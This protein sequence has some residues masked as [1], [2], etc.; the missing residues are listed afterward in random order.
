MWHI[1]VPA[2]TA[3]LGSGFDSLGMALS[4]PLEC[5]YSEAP[6][7]IISARG[8]GEGVVAETEEN[9]VWKTA[10]WLYRDYTGNPLPS[11][12]L[13]VKSR[14]PLARG[15]G[16]SAA[17]I[18]AGLTLANTLLPERLS[19][20]TLLD[21][22]TR[23][24]GHPDNVA[25]A[26]YGGFV[27]AW[28]DGQ[29]FRVQNYPAPDLR[30]LVLIPDFPVSTEKARA[31][32]PREVPLADAVFNAQRLALWIDAVSRRDWT[33]LRHA[34]GDRLHQPYRAPLIPGLTAVIDA[35]LGAGAAFAALS[36]SGPTLLS[37]MTSDVVAD[38][39]QAMGQASSMHMPGAIQLI[40]ATPSYFGAECVLDGWQ[41]QRGEPQGRNH[42]QPRIAC[43]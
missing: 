5:W 16:S 29:K 13:T 40:D 6:E 34:G 32:L 36:G 15:L 24:E 19:R 3:N 22:A 30:C 28:H 4:L 37:L 12:H 43:E 21:Y 11:G 39:A 20:Q 10:D 31:V 41:W 42:R 26:L 7:T 1:K 18:V 35:A 33:L 23:A 27:L 38:V 17:A 25:A 8:E 9:L 2:T 14:I